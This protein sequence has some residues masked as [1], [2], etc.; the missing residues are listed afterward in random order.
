M[1]AW[2][3]DPR[4]SW[5]PR[6]SV[7]DTFEGDV[8]DYSD[9]IKGE[10]GLQQRDNPKCRPHLQETGA[11]VGQCCGGRGHVWRGRHPRQPRVVVA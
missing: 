4:S 9:K 7:R 6:F 3:L 5:C 8:L 10:L 11:D 1:A 2:C